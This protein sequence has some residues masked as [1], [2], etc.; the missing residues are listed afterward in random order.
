MFSNLIIPS[1]NT[2]DFP[3]NLPQNPIKYC[4]SFD[5]LSDTSSLPDFTEASDFLYP[6]Q[7]H[8]SS[9]NK[10]S[11]K[12]LKKPSNSPAQ[13][14]R[15]IW[16]ASEDKL[17]W[18]LYKT[19]GAQWD[20]ISECLE[21]KTGAQVKRRFNTYLKKNAEEQEESY[22]DLMEALL[23]RQESYSRQ[24]SGQETSGL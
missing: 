1:P 5:N 22:K 10:S 13:R 7:N 2:F 19:V 4:L 20:K 3:L 6:E 15:A 9:L 24:N 8:T 21:G 18:L 11:K 23:E 12:I 17:I 14:K 16:S